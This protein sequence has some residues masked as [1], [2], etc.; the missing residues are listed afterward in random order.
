MSSCE[1]ATKNHPSRRGLR[2]KNAQLG[3]PGAFKERNVYVT[4]IL[5][6]RPTLTR[7]P[8]LRAIVEVH[9]AELFIYPIV[10]NDQDEALVLNALRFIREDFELDQTS[11]AHGKAL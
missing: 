5:L 9:G 4:D 3:R 6:P 7:Q 10:D 2:K 1:G 8:P 11:S